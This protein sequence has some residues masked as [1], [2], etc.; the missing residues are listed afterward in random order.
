VLAKDPAARDLGTVRDSQGRGVALDYAG[1]Q[2]LAGAQ[3]FQVV[4]DPQ[5]SEILEWSMQVPA[6]DA[7]RGSPSR[8]VTVLDTGYAR[9]AG[10]R[11]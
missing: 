10:D 4:F 5:T 8:T 3:S 1:R 2:L 7:H 9:Q 11:P 6:G